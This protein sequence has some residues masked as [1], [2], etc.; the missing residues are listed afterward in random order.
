VR[1]PALDRGAL[2]RIA[3][4]VTPAEASDPADDPAKA[5]DDYET[6]LARWRTLRE[7]ETGGAAAEDRTT[8][9]RRMTTSHPSTHVEGEVSVAAEPEPRLRPDASGPL[10][11]A[12]P[13]SVPPI[14]GRPL[15]AD[16][17]R[18]PQPTIVPFAPPGAPAQPLPDDRSVP[19]DDAAKSAQ[20]PT[21]PAWPGAVKSRPE[22]AP[23]DDAPGDDK[24]RRAGNVVDLPRPPRN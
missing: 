19:P 12:I 22:A 15:P 1:S 4:P 16:P 9:S 24:A 17:A 6:A 10:V 5:A 2:A 14:P 18:A 7:A 11:S 20:P 8:S 13:I 23:D 21:P 3:A